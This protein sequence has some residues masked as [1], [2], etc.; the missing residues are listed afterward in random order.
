MNPIWLVRMSQW[1]RHP[2]P[3]WKVLL[4]LAVIA[5][6]IALFL[7]ERFVGWP[8]W[9]TTNGKTHLRVH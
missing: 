6:C 2:P 1:V 4:A 3:M 9:L 7:V 8:D 5:A